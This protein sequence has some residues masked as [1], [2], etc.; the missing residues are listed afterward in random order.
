MVSIKKSELVELYAVLKDL[1]NKQ[2]PIKF[3][4]ANN[5]A[6]IE[7]IVQ[8]YQRERE[9]IF[10]E[11]VKIDQNGDP[12]LT[13]DAKKELNWKEGDQI[14]LELPFVAYEYE[15][16]LS[17]MI[18]KMGMLA[19][20][21]D[22]IDFYQEDINRKISIKVNENGKEIYKEV[23]ILSLIE[24]PNSPILPA[25]IGLLAKFC[26]KNLIS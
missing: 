9:K 4:V 23:S 24:D 25:H 5:L 12:V 13:Q 1:S 26:F 21:V 10:W 11:H 18:K 8:N 7:P 14:P 6:L 16:P 15:K 22:E 17:E 19:E 3:N 2:I 20:T